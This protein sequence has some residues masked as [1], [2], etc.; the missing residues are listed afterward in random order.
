MKETI[1]PALLLAA[2]LSACPGGA[3]AEVR[4]VDPGAP[5]GG[6]GLT[7]ETALD[8]IQAGIDASAAGDQV[9]V[10]R[11]SYGE[12]LVMKDGVR[13]YGHFAGTENDAA[14]R[15]LSDDAA[16]SVVDGGNLA[17]AIAVIDC[18]DPGTR[19]DGFTFQNGKATGMY[20]GGGGIHI[21]RSSPGIYNNLI[22]NNSAEWGGGG[23][24]FSESSPTIASN[25]FTGNIAPWGGGLTCSG[26]P[27][28]DVHGNTFH[29]NANSGM[30]AIGCSGLTVRGNEFVENSSGLGGGIWIASSAGVTVAG[31]RF[32]R[33]ESSAYDGGGAIGSSAASTVIV[34]N[35]MAENRAGYGVGGGGI[36]LVRDSSSLVANNIV[37]FGTSGIFTDNAD[38]LSLSRNDVFGNGQ[39][40]YAGLA[41]GSGDISADP[42]FN[43]A[44]SNDYRLRMDS[45]CINAGDN[46]VA[47]L[48]GE[49][50]IDGE[51]RVNAADGSAVID[52]GADEYFP[53]AVAPLV[54]GA[55]PAEGAEG[56]LLG[57]SVTL[58]F[59]EN[60]WAVNA[61]VD[62]SI[63]YINKKGQAVVLP[64]SK[65]LAGKT[66]TVDPA[67]YLPSGT[68]ILVSVDA[69]AV[70]DFEG[71]GL[72]QPF[73]LSF[74]TGRTRR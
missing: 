7:W 49:A 14:S 32:V 58:T 54:A 18:P 26:S 6:D 10:K 23:L 63:R 3:S 72:A 53:D 35:T 36:S 9:W 73:L 15:D 42:A 39:Y 56:V 71:N 5:P 37:A 59:S 28:G 13:L 57:Q 50:D 51:G 22:R 31:N 70:A 65:T 8:R 17:P 38:A 52:I 46:G 34:N 41:P 67:D 27:G 47:A 25:A 62:V 43:D 2:L 12:N 64:C 21:S 4:H 16:A 33:N 30:Q 60:V 69:G 61:L 29:A 19:I 74:T 44:A 68:R 24:L 48:A 40:D 55:S 11:G 66:L 1:I 20:S 45:P